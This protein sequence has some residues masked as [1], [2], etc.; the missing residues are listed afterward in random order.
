LPAIPLN[1]RPYE[2]SIWRHDIF[3]PL[4]LDVPPPLGI[5]GNPPPPRGYQLFPL[6]YS[7]GPDGLYELAQNTGFSTV[8]IPGIGQYSFPDP[9]SYNPTSNN[10]LGQS[11]SWQDSLNG[12]YSDGQDESKDNITNHAI[13]TSP[14]Q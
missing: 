12:P 1:Q 14:R 2:F 3:D 4:K 9:Y 13:G 7:A 8:T 6:V 11:G 10:P 5:N